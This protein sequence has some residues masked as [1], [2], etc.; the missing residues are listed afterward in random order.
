MYNIME[1]NSDRHLKKRSEDLMLSLAG[2]VKKGFNLSSPLESYRFITIFF[3]TN[4]VRN[5]SH[6]SAVSLP[7]GP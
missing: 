4:T 6:L 2:R 3:Q 5:Y 7:V 1:H